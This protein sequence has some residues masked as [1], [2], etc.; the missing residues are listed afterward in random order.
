MY[1]YQVGSIYAGEIFKF[2]ILTAKSL[3]NQ[4]R[5]ASIGF[6]LY[7]NPKLRGKM[8]AIH[9]PFDEFRPEN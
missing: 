4:N 9:G 8:K 6:K 3:V 1:T 7:K 5:F 2:K